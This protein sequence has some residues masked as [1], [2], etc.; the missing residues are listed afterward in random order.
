MFIHVNQPS[1]Q[2][3]PNRIIDGRRWYTVPN[4]EKYASITT[5]LGHEEKEW[6]TNWKKAL[7]EKKAA[8]EQ[9][10]CSERGDAVHLMAEKYLK[11]ESRVT[12]GHDKDHIFLFN[13]LTYAL[14][15]INNIRAQ[16][17]PLFSDEMR[18]AGRCDCIGEYDGELSII[19]FKTSTNSKKGNMIEDYKLQTTAYALMF[20][21]MFNIF[22]KQAV[23]LIAAE[24]GLLPLVFKIDT[25]EFVIPL[26]D[27]INTFYKEI[28]YIPK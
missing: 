8:K 4:G 23:I 11:N 27:R 10:R 20:F 15:K 25:E 3:L 14:D 1:Y 28:K 17:I 24:K 16:E 12:E 5:I 2:E 6:L 13:K 18:V 26:T 21:E 22:I 19:D 9:K 7:G